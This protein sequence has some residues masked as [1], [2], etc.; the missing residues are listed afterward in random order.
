MDPNEHAL[1][2]QYHH[3]LIHIV[4]NDS[5][6]HQNQFTFLRLSSVTDDFGFKSPYF[7]CPE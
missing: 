7:E 4:C 2:D 1:D 6:P 3:V 5:F